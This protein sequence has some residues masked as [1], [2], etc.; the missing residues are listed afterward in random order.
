MQVNI[1]L[2]LLLQAFDFNHLNN[3]LVSR[4]H[5]SVRLIDVSL[6]CAIYT[7]IFCWLVSL[8]IVFTPCRLMVILKVPLSTQSSRARPAIQTYL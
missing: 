6:E 7:Y 5:R 2:H 4:D 3:V 1:L 8:L